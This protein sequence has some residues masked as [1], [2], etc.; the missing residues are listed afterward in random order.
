MSQKWNRSDLLP[1]MK[2]LEKRLG[3]LEFKMIDLMKKMR[4]WI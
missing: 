3:E 2:L 4:K 1:K